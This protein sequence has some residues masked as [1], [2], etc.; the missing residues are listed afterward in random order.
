MR[1]QH[2]ELL[3]LLIKYDLDAAYRRLHIIARMAVLAITILKNIAY[4]LLRLPFGVANGPSDYCVIS[5]PVVDLSNDILRDN[6]WDP[7]KTYSPLRSKFDKPTQRYDDATPFEPA[8]PLFVPVPYAPA[9]VDGYIDDL[10]TCVVFTD[11]WLERAQNAAPLAIHCAFRPTDP[12]DSLPRADPISE[13]KLKG[14]GTPDEKKT[15]LGWD[16][17]TR[18]FRVYLPRKKAEEWKREISEIRKLETVATK[19]L[20]TTIGRLNHA[21]HIIPQGRYFLNRLRHL[22]QNTKNYGPQPL[23]EAHREDLELWEAFLQKV[24]IKGININSITFTTPTHTTFSDACEHGLGGFSTNGWAWRYELPHELI[25]QFSINLLEFLAVSITISLI[26]RNTNSNTKILA[27]TDSSS[28]LGW[29]HK[30][31]FASNQ[32]NHDKTALYKTNLSST[33][34]TRS[35]VEA[36]SRIVRTEDSRRFP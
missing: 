7:S 33:P 34:F 10:I 26:S 32:R 4:I 19:R 3:I 30:A 12:S 17:D 31:S 27:F 16:I 9:V 24:S 18:K 14:E 20:E 15:V 28:A 13:R 36:L 8:R 29:L 21:G 1:I 22:L 23:N 6:S 25:G 5:E 35:N 2:P 11:K